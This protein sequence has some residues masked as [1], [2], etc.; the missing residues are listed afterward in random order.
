[1]QKRL[2]F[3]CPTDGLE[4]AIENEFEQDNYFYT[5]LGNSMSLN[6]KTLK[7]IEELIISQ[8]IKKIYFVLSSDNKIVAD[9]LGKQNLFEVSSLRKF[10]TEITRCKEYSEF[11]SKTNCYHSL[12]ISYF[13]NKKIKDFKDK[14]E[15]M[16]YFPIEIHGKIYNRNDGIFKTIYSNLIC[17]ENLCLN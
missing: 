12:I 2:F 14:V 16:L 7:D 11:W 5:S 6:F 10:Y 13:L 9:A 8:H 4:V 17:L 1:M 15:N 3:L